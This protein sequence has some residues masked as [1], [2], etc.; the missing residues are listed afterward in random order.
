VDVE[1][2]KMEEVGLNHA[3]V[4]QAHGS[5]HAP[6]TANEVTCTALLPFS[7]FYKLSVKCN[8]D[9]ALDSDGQSQWPHSLRHELSLPA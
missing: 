9:K 3:N 7:L 1:M 8:Y 4:T 2:K 5:F 6:P